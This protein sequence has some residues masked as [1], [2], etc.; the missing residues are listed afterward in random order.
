[1]N[2]EDYV[3][4]KPNE[5]ET[6]ALVVFENKLEENIRA[7]VQQVGGGANLMPHVKTHK[8]TEILKRQMAAGIRKFKCATL[9]EC[10]MVA[11]K[12]ADE[13]LLAYPLAQRRKIERFLAMQEQYAHT[14][15][16]TL[17]S[18]PV[19]LELLSQAATGAQATVS[20]MVD[21]D[22]GMHR[23]GIDPG[24]PAFRLSLEIARMPA[25]T[26]GGLHAYD[27]HNNQTDPTD[28]ETAAQK[29]LSIV[30]TLQQ[31]LEQEGVETPSIVMGGSPCYPYYARERGIVGSPGT[32]VYW[33][34]T[35]MHQM[36]DMPFRCAAL[37][38]TQVVDTNPALG[39]ATLDLGSKAI[40]SDKETAGRAEF[41]GYP[42]VSLVKQNEEHG[43]VKTNDHELS[44][45][46]Y[47]LAIPGHVCTAVAR[48][49]GAFLLDSDGNV[50]GWIEND[51]R[52]R[53]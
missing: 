52:D 21:L 48:Y 22:V 11:R 51:A 2:W 40:C 8:S 7:L 49:P 1:M 53:N 44:I 34:A 32:V 25:L 46:D 35:Y 24:E 37:V 38:L 28:R 4:A 27:G 45:G 18:S 42:N 30:R 33:D 3:V 36:P 17:A 29:A 50:N 26:F 47:L 41:P 10:E 13:L 9:K 5:I 19:H 43:V 16:S 14:K 31:Q 6:P 20:V 12:G 39:L 23:T 15:W